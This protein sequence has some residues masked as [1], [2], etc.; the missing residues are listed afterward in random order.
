[1][2]G[3]NTRSASRRPLQSNRSLSNVDTGDI[4]ILSSDDESS[5]IPKKR[6]SQ[7]SSSRGQHNKVARK[8]IVVPSCEIV[9]ISSDEETVPPPVAS[10]SAAAALQVQV[11]A[12]QEENAR[13][14]LQQVVSCCS[15]ALK[16][17]PVRRDKL[18]YWRS[19]D[20]MDRGLIWCSLQDELL[21]S[22]EER[23]S[24]EICVGLMWSP[25]LLSCGHTFCLSCLQDWFSTTLAK[26]MTENPAYNPNPPVLQQYHAFLRH[27]HI[28]PIQ[29]REVEES[30]QRLLTSMKHPTYT[31]PTCREP[32][33]DKPTEVYIVKEMVRAVAEKQGVP[34]PKRQMPPRGTKLEGPWD[35]FFPKI[36]P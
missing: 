35:G 25:Y 2:P 36:H 1:M 29:R 31:C 13:L 12:L 17:R 18:R 34:S 22:F 10:S 23:L 14:K 3:P 8:N 16:R 26:H 21:K 20:I 6:P 32:I 4:I 15:L 5:T 19:C 27:P 30:I 7:M 9:E 11:K 24:C 28:T 33:K